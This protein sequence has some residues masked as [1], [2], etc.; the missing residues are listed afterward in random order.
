MS[1]SI[2]PALSR[3]LIEYR[4]AAGSPRRCLPDHAAVLFRPHH[5]SASLALKGGGELRHIRKRP[6]DPEL[7]QRMRVRTHQ[8]TR[9]LGPDVFRPA[10]RITKKEAL[11][12]RETV[13]VRGSRFTLEGLLKSRIGDYQAAEVGDRFTLDQLTVF[14]QP[15]F[16]FEAV[17]LF[18]DALS[19]FVEGLEVGIAPPGL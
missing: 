10:A 19:A 18:D 6:I 13:D 5:R 12:R 3:L 11:L 1:A 4:M 9:Q 7:C 8:Q 15:L 14:V 16:N 17:E 2:P